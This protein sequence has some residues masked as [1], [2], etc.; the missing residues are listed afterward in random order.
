MKKKL[1]SQDP[2]GM[3]MVEGSYGA[4]K[5]YNTHLEALLRKR[6]N[7]WNLLIANTPYDF[8]D[9]YYSS[10]EDFSL[11]LKYFYRFLLDNNFRLWVDYSYVRWI[12]DEAHVYFFTRD[13]KSFD[14]KLVFLM[15]QVRKVNLSF[16]II[17][18]RRKQIDSFVRELAPE[19]IYYTSWQG[20]MSRLKKRDHIYFSDSDMNNP[21]EAEIITSTMLLPPF[22]DRWLFK[23]DKDLQNFWRQW[24][25]TNY[26]V[27]LEH[28][29][30]V[31]WKDEKTGKEKLIPTLTYEAFLDIIKPFYPFLLT[32]NVEE[33]ENAFHS[34]R[35]DDV[36]S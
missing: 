31:A 5:S 8:V 28:E 25:L 10:Y 21:D 9:L 6:E 14:K 13:F 12:I 36:A 35:I 17:S 27:W 24:R 16:Y 30:F 29:F 7:P 4:G 32:E 22:L 18:Q 26:L 3:Y 20:I 34:K 33:P 2:F 1:S 11:L 15:T 23:W 19:S